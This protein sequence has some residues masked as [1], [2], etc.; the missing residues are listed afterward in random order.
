MI[1]VCSICKLSH[2]YLVN[3]SM[4][5]C[6]STNINMGMN[7]LSQLACVWQLLYDF[8]RI[9]V[10]SLISLAFKSAIHIILHHQSIGLIINKIALASKTKRKLMMATSTLSW[11]APAQACS[12]FRNMALFV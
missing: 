8:D 2:S 3:D 6:T 5:E 1:N 9:V 4:N 12:L 11:R 7:E 10:S